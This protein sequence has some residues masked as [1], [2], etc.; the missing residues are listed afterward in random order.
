MPVYPVMGS[1]CCCLLCHSLV[2]DISYDMPSGGH[3]VY[4]DAAAFLPHIPSWQFP[5]HAVACAFYLEGGV[6]ACELGARRASKCPG[7]LL[8]QR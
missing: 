3:A 6:R 4:I 7:W 1:R 5:G 2:P 8:I